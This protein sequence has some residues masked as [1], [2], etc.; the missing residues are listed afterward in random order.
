MLETA[1]PVVHTTSLT[2]QGLKQEQYI[3]MINN[4]SLEERVALIN[5]VGFEISLHSRTYR[6]RLGCGQGD[7]RQSACRRRKA[8]AAEAVETCI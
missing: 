3:Q 6:R 7:V 5:H 8:E 2:P 1:G 4:L